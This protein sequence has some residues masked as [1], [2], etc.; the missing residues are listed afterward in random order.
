M[1]TRA[2][3]YYKRSHRAWYANIG[4]KQVRLS[5]DEASA[6]V[7]FD[8]LVGRHDYTVSETIALFLAVPRVKSTQ[9]FYQQG[10]TALAGVG[11]LIA[12][13]LKIHQVQGSRNVRRAA[14][15]CFKWAEEQQYIEQSPLRFL[16]IPQAPARGDEAYLSPEQVN[17]L[18]ASM[19]GDLLDLAVVMRETGCRPQEVR[20]VEA[21]HFDREG[22]CWVFPREESKGKREQ[23]IVH[24]SDRAFAIC[25][26]LALKRPEG[27]L[28]RRGNRPWT[29]RALCRRF[30]RFGVTSYQLRHTFA[31]EAILRGVDLQTIAV[32]MG[33]T[34][35]KMLSRI[36]Q[37]I[38]RRADFIK[39]G[40]R[41][42]SG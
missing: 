32:L 21:R 14:K 34:D 16:K 10:L 38:R 13:D 6:Q 15:T 22:R 11:H 27:S 9:R 1:K 24:L 28:F 26:R 41:K 17:K 25:Q 23:R 40:L 5:T 4:G 18:L 31:T 29:A 36:Y 3:P 2:R 39:E 19:Q 20:R 35:L 8:K 33:H 12:K 37:H 30:K 42:I 7:E